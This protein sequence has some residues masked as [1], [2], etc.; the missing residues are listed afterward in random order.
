MNR[1]LQKIEEETLDIIFYEYYRH[2]KNICIILNEL[3]SKKYTVVDR[4][5]LDYCLIYDLKYNNVIHNLHPFFQG[6]ILSITIPNFG[7]Y[8]FNCGEEYES[9]CIPK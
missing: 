6:M 5:V 4:M 1:N 8:I 9:Y 3:N 7:T 2:L